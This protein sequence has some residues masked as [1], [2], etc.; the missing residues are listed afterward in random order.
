MKEQGKER[1]FGAGIEI[2]HFGF[3]LVVGKVF[4]FR[5]QKGLIGFLTKRRKRN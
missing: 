5:F 4:D 2:G 1:R 3:L